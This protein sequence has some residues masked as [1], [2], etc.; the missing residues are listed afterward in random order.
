MDCSCGTTE[1]VLKE[2]LQDH[3]IK[4]ITWL[5]GMLAESLGQVTGF[6]CISGRRYSTECKGMTLIL[7]PSLTAFGIHILDNL[8]RPLIFSIIKDPGVLGL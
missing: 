6:T 5:S 1:M 8:L 3:K 2:I 4:K 7:V